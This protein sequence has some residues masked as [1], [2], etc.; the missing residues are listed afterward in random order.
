[1][2]LLYWS[3]NERTYYIPPTQATLA[4]YGKMAQFCTGPSLT[5][6]PESGPQEHLLGQSAFVTLG[7]LRVSVTKYLWM[8]P[9][10]V[11]PNSNENPHLFG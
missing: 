2:Q 11:F 4:P 3:K 5:V 7:S 8:G 9:K 6:S 10:K 1:M